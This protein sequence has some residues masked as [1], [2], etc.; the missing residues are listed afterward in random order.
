MNED[1]G[2]SSVASESLSP[3][4]EG[5]W[6]NWLIDD[7]DCCALAH[8]RLSQCF[9]YGYHVLQRFTKETLESCTFSV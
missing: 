8:V 3:D 1:D 6:K 2:T 7:P 9:A 5:A 4:L